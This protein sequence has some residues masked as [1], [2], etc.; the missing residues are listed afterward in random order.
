[1]PEEEDEHNTNMKKT[2]TPKQPKRVAAFGQRRDLTTPIQR[3]FLP[4]YHRA[5]VYSD[6]RTLATASTPSAIQYRLTNLFDVDPLL[7]GHSPYGFDQI[8]AIYTVYH[9]L[10]VSYRITVA[11]NVGNNGVVAA[12][13]VSPDNSVS[14]VATDYLERADTDIYTLSTAYSKN[15]IHTFTGRVYPWTALGIPKRIYYDNVGYRGSAAAGPI[16]DGGFLNILAVSH[17][18]ASTPTTLDVIVQLSFETEFSQPVVL[19]G[20][21]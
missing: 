21:T 13:T 19:A 15:S 2:K 8:K 11:N 18:S 1:M 3:P 12:I 6:I 17:M 16:L 5:L 9:V 4:V 20:S 10:S 14:S 7:G